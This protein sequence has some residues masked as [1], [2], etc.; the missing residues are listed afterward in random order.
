[1]D[2]LLCKYKECPKCGAHYDTLYGRFKCKY[3][4]DWVMVKDPIYEKASWFSPDRLISGG[5]M[6]FF[7]QL[8]WKCYRCGYTWITKCADDK[9]RQETLPISGDV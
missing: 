7:E 2:K 6:E 1:M 5:T 3:Q 8:E 4:S 9:K